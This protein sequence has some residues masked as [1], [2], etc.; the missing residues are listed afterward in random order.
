MDRWLDA[1]HELADV[2]LLC[3]FR[4]HEW[5]RPV[6]KSDPPSMLLKRL[7][8]SA[9]FLLRNRMSAL[10]RADELL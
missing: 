5:P 1:L 7:P 8:Y 2:L 4:R 10:E 3:E 9:L 6:L